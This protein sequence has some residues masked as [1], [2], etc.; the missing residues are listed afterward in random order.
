MEAGACGT[1]TAALRVGGLASRSSTARPALLADE[2]ERARRGACASWSTTPSAATRSAHAAHARAPR[3]HVGRTRRAGTLDVHRDGRGGDRARGALRDA[4][5]ARRSGKAAG[6]AGG[7]AR[8]QRDPAGLHDRLHAPARRRPATGRWPR[9]ISAF[10]IL[11]VGGPVGAGR[12]GARGGA[13]TAWATRRVLRRDAA[14]WTLR[15]LVALV[16]GDRGVD[17]AARAAGDAD[18][19]ARAPVGGRGDPA[20]RR[21]V[22]AALA[23]ARRAAGPARLRPGRRLDRRRGGRPARLRPDP[24]R[25]SA[26]A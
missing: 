21:A 20:H 4:L 17:P 13:R 10:L 22:D 6:L 14:A 24:G 12:G 26:R 25:R 1:P 3:L 2:P 19:R 9:S 5:R 23:P 15:L 11:L 7:D 8:Q 16:G 18:R